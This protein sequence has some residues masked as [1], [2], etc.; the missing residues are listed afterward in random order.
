M[1]TKPSI[2]KI[3]TTALKLVVPI[4]IVN[5]F[6]FFVGDILGAFPEGHTAPTGA[7]V[8]I[9][10]VISASIVGVIISAIIYWI[11]T[12]LSKNHGKV[13]PIIGYLVL[14]LS[15]WNPAGIEDGN[16]GTFIV[17][18]LMHVVVGVVM[19]QA[20]TKLSKQSIMIKDTPQ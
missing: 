2:G 17:L 7:S 13:T 4:V 1:T 11:I 10:A 19:I 12:L 3:F 6:L 15:F 5:A 20:Y 14:L 9:I 18:N 16:I 8:Q